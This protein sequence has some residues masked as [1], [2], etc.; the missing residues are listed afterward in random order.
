MR[1]IDWNI[2]V[3]HLTGTSSEAEERELSAWIAEGEH[4]RILYGRIKDLWTA[5]LNTGRRPDTE[6]ALKLVLSRIQHPE[7]SKQAPITPISSIGAVQRP[8]RVF[9]LSLVMRAA[10][11]LIVVIGAVFLY[12]LLK[13]GRAS[14]KT[15]VTFSTMQS[16]R[17][18]DGTKVTFDVGSSFTY[19]KVFGG[20]GGREVF[21]KGEAFFEVAR[22]EQ[23]PFIIHADGARV[24]ILGTKFDVRA[25]GTE[26]HISVAVQ[27]GKVSF[28]SEQNKDESN[29]VL[30]TANSASTLVRGSTPSPAE[31][32]DITA[33]L[34]WMKK[35]IYFRNTPVPEVLHQLERWYG[36]DIQTADTAFLK[37]NI[38][39]FIENKPLV[40]NLK[41]IDMT[42]NVRHEQ[43]GNVV[44]F[45]PN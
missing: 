16:L 21:L 23:H 1:T 7:I 44:R 6:E 29:I 25:W 9:P 34:S 38:T 2:L 35:E 12:T 20:D 33:F 5:N 42:M 10:A 4:N 36:I 15:S 8:A 22:D 30:L 18:P 43:L 26:E 32:T 28:Q 40:D 17:L 19:P 24:E 41:L 27:E 14:E 11:V 13:S 37:S 3:N 45:L 31:P 39:V